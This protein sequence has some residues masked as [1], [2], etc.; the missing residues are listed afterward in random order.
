MS[1]RG[2]TQTHRMLLQLAEVTNHTCAATATAKCLKH[3]GLLLPVQFPLT[4]LLP[5]QPTLLPA[6]PGTTV[7]A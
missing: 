1:Q 2:Q 4:P 6:L 3:P 7:M 5:L